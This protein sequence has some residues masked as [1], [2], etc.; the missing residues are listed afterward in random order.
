MKAKKPLFSVIIPTFNSSAFIEKAI[1]SVLKQT[2][3]DWELLIIDD[4]SS[5]NTVSIIKNFKNEKNIKVIKSP[6]NLGAAT[7]RNIGIKKSKGRYIAFLD[8][9][10]YWLPNK[11]ALQFKFLKNNTDC[12][13][14]CSNYF[15]EFS[16]SNDKLKQIKFRELIYFK[17]IIRTNSI[18][19]SSA[20]FDSKLVSNIYMPNLKRRQDWAFWISIL[21]KDKSFKAYCIQTPLAVKVVNQNSLS[22]NRISSLYFNFLA[23]SM[24]GDVSRYRA[25]RLIT[26]NLLRVL[27]R[28]IKSGLFYL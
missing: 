14:V 17:D 26:L 2:F 16:S 1:N 7:A 18:M 22:S 5:D 8:S 9:D 24:Y 11:L 21:K 10:D 6:F 20:V 4:N 12:P 19:T 15:L 27:F 28:R 23:I 3:K 25:L 13:I